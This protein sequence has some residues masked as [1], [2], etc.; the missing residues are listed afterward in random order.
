MML[1]NF[2]LIGSNKVTGTL[3]LLHVKNNYRINF[4]P[5]RINNDGFITVEVVGYQNDDYQ[6][7]DRLEKAIKYV[8]D[9]SSNV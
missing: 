8:N 1:D 3:T 5:N 2:D 7:F 4:L 6:K 9:I